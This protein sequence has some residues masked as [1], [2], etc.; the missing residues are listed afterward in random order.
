MRLSPAAI[1]EIPVPFI[2]STVD[3][4]RIENAGALT[5]E[6]ADKSS[7]DSIRTLTI[8]SLNLDNV[9]LIKVDTQGND[10]S[11]LKGA[12]KTISRCRPVIVFEYEKELSH[13]HLES[14]VH[15]EEYFEDLH[16]D[17]KLLATQIEGKQSDYL[18]T[19]RPQI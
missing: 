19:P 18:A 5:F 6:L 1:Q 9:G 17:L 7:V 11:V 10:F 2:E 14:F 13:L 4:D 16:Y 8:D 3:Y 12:R 15:F